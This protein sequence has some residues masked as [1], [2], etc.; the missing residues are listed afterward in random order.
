MNEIWIWR[1]RIDKEIIALGVRT[2]TGRIAWVAGL[3][4]ACLSDLFGLSLYE[5]VK[6]NLGTEPKRVLVQAMMDVQ[7]DVEYGRSTEE[8]KLT[9]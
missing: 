3:H 1:D 9:P 7:V 5:Q 4:I 2:V 8:A 6:L